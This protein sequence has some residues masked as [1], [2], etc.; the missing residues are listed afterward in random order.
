VDTWRQDNCTS[1][2]YIL[3]G[4]SSDFYIWPVF[5]A[6]DSELY[7]SSGSRIDKLK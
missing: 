7:G 1:Q 4:A 6:V 5:Y 3:G 2:C